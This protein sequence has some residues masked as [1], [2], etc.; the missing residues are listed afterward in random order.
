LTTEIIHPSW[1]DISTDALKVMKA[2]VDGCG[3]KEKEK[4][5]SLETGHRF[6]HSFE[7]G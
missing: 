2:A 3:Q 6:V 5:R 7:S 4:G 1:R